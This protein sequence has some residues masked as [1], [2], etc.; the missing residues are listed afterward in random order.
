MALDSLINRFLDDRR[1]SDGSG[2]ACITSEDMDTLREIIHE[3][4]E[5]KCE[6][7]ADGDYPIEFKLINRRTHERMC[8]RP[9]PYRRQQND[10]VSHA[11]LM[12]ILTAN[13]RLAADS[14]TVEVN[15]EEIRRGI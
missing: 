6:P 11:E 15:G 1:K 12:R 4:I 8:Y 5:L 2:W 7:D 13:L 9:L 14:L 3:L 10:T